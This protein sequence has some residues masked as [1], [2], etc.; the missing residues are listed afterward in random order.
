MKKKKLTS[1]IQ[2]IVCFVTVVTFTSSS[3]V[4]SFPSK[5]IFRKNAL[6]YSTFFG[7]MDPVEDELFSLALTSA[8]TWIASKK[9]ENRNQPVSNESFELF[10]EENKALFQKN[11]RAFKRY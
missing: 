11:T 10:L 3:I 5:N 1:G 8:V 4:F 6:Q 7:V 2:K 9:L